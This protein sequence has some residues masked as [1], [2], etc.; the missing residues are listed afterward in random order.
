MLTSTNKLLKEPQR[1]STPKL[2][3][4]SS[5]Y[6]QQPSRALSSNTNQQQYIRTS[7]VALPRAEET[8]VMGVKSK[9]LKQITLTRT[10]QELPPQ[11]PTINYVPPVPIVQQQTSLPPSMKLSQVKCPLCFDPN[12]CQVLGVLQHGM[13]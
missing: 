8:A 6:L 5:Q 2:T 12:D 13:C 3:R 1:V 4:P 11:Q 9:Q 7:N 10:T